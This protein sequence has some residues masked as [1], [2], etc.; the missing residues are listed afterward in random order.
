MALNTVRVERGRSRN[1]QN[2]RTTDPNEARLAED[3]GGASRQAPVAGR[4]PAL[5]RRLLDRRQPERMERPFGMHDHDPWYCPLT[6]ARR[7][8]TGSAQRFLDRGR[9]AA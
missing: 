4:R 6:I 9:A 1:S 3:D 5:Q 7:D 8:S 2:S